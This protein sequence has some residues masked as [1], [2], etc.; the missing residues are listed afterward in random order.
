MRADAVT[1]ELHAAVLLRDR[2]CV[3]SFL[4]PGH[5]CRD[6]WGLTHDPADL[7][8]LTLEHVHDGYGRMGKRAPSDMA[9]LVALCGGANVSVPSKVQRQAMRA[10]LESVGER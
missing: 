5:V 1:T 8:R 3:L 4:S 7:G 6:A 10:Y 2:R 9:H